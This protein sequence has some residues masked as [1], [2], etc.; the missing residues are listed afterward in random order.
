MK[1]NL[2]EELRTNSELRNQFIIDTGIRTDDLEDTLSDGDLGL[3]VCYL[4]DTH[5][6]F[7]Y[8]TENGSCTVVSWR[9]YF[10]SESEWDDLAG[11]FSSLEEA[12]DPIRYLLEY[13]DDC[14][15]DSVSHSVENKLAD[16]ETFKVIAKLAS[17]KDVVEVNGVKYH[18]TKSGYLKE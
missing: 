2:L 17:I 18:R 7:H 8:A 3:I 12:L 4:E 10:F 14:D 1:L 15:T 9:G 5:A 6:L 16:E 13:G 11:P